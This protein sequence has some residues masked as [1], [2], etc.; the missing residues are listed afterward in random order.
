MFS[1]NADIKNSSGEPLKPQIESETQL[2]Y[3]NSNDSQGNCNV[4]DAT[5]PNVN[6]LNDS[7][8]QYNL[9]NNIEGSLGENDEKMQYTNDKT[10]ENNTEKSLKNNEEHI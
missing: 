4:D 6:R 1:R 9:N 10:L 3:V 5:F 7:F 2:N 8:D